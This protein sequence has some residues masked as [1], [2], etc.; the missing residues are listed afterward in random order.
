MSEAPVQNEVMPSVQNP[1][2]LSYSVK[3]SSASK[4]RRMDVRPI[5]NATITLGAATTQSIIEIPQGCYNLSKSRLVLTYAIPAT[6]VANTNVNV[7]AHCPPIARLRVTTQNSGL[8]LIDL[9]DFPAYW[10]GTR[11]LSSFNSWQGSNAQLPYD[12]ADNLVNSSNRYHS[13]TSNNAAINSA[14]LTNQRVDQ[15]AAIGDV[16]TCPPGILATQYVA[17]GADEVTAI[18]TRFSL[19]FSQMHGTIFSLDKVLPIN[20][21]LV[22][23]IDYVAQN[24]L[25]F[26][27]AA[28]FAA[29][30]AIGALA[31]TNLTPV[32]Q[33]MQ[34]CNPEIVRQLADKARAGMDVLYPIINQSTQTIT[35]N[36]TGSAAFAHSKLG[37]NLVANLVT[38]MLTDNN[39]ALRASAFDYQGTT[40]NNHRALLNSF[41]LDV[42]QINHV[43]GEDWQEYSKYLQSS[44]INLVDYVSL[45]KSYIY[46]YGNDQD[47]AMSDLSQAQGYNVA[48]T[49]MPQLFVNYVAGAFASRMVSNAIFQDTI[50]LTESGFSRPD[51]VPINHL[52]LMELPDRS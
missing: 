11:C 43:T 15:T 10:A 35:A 47:I 23:V 20:D 39:V 29:L 6:G 16:Q 5:T 21:R 34:E 36:T 31:N 22:V 18:A 25:G 12:V 14:I 17:C 40:I 24:N 51:S 13:C 46:W 27:A 8:V 19:D 48:T 52:A 4:L 28:A 50:R 1:S 32:M 41:P 33:L 49:Q 7:F 9:S 3:T 42:Q 2:S 38:T 37:H 45:F 26:T 44:A 30:S